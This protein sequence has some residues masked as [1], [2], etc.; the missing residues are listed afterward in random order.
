MA[1]VEVKGVD[2]LLQALDQCILR[3]D[4]EAT[5]GMMEIADE[6]EGLMKVYA[7]VDTGALRDSIEALRRGDLH[8][9]VSM[10]YYGFFQEYGT[11]KMS[12]QPFVQPALDRIQGR[13]VGILWKHL[14]RL[15]RSDRF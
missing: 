4:H 11:Y 1:V 8:V 14:G 5:D 12:P 6:L 15:F 3:F 10:L 7:P 9:A 13:V 2:R